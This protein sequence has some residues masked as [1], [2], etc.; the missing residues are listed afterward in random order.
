M[1]LGDNNF[2]QNTTNLGLT[3]LFENPG[4][5]ALKSI[6]VAFGAEMRIENYQIKA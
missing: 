3:K 4:N 1:R 6:N 2:I 5:G